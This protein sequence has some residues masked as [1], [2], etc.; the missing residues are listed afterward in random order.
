MTTIVKT[1]K[2]S[3][4]KATLDVAIISLGVIA[5]GLVAWL[6]LWL[7][8]DFTAY[9]DQSYLSLISTV[10]QATVPGPIHTFYTDQAQ[11]MALP[12]T[13][14]TSAYWYMARA[15]GIVG[16]LL[17]W[18]A[19]VWGLLISTKLAGQWIAPLLSY[20]LHEFLSILALL[21]ISLHGLVLLGDRY[22]NFNIFH[23][24]LPFSAP[25][26]PFWTGLGTLAFYLS[27]ALTLSFYLRRQIG[28]KI[29]RTL[30]YLTFVAYALSLLHALGAGTDTASTLMKSV[31]LSTGLLV[32]F[33]INYRLLSLRLKPA[34]A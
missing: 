25:Y 19:V 32:M 13:G 9:Q 22:I 11:L 3:T 5:G 23:L 21:F 17:L 27:L 30:H 26:E 18:L 4:I 16:Y 24:L 33:L 15:G 12:L 28:Q 31:Y 20:G 2:S 10:L 6:G 8:W 14:Q 34:K 29:W 7:W 1:R